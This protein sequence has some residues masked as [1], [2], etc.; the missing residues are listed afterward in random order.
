MDNIVKN[1]NKTSTEEEVK[2]YLESALGTQPVDLFIKGWTGEPGL[3][4]LVLLPPL[5]LCPIC[6]VSWGWTVDFNILA[7]YLVFATLIHICVCRCKIKDSLCANVNRLW[8]VTGGLTRRL[9]MKERWS[10][11]PLIVFSV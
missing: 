3:P 4:S 10:L 1:A 6:S 8:W 11:S 9:P 5:L 2:C 7:A